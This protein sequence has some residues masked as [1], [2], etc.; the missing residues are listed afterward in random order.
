MS[1]HLASVSA[2]ITDQNI[3]KFSNFFDFVFMLLT[4]IAFIV[5]FEYIWCVARFG[6]IWKI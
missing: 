2:D 4:S 6:T 5:D 3:N 1:Q